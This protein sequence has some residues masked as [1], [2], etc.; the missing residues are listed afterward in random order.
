MQNNSVQTR[1]QILVAL[2]AMEWDLIK[3]WAM[4]GHSA[5]FRRLLEEGVHGEDSPGTGS[6]VRP[7][8]RNEM[9]NLM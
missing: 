5:T 7:H 4:T 1:R 6:T 3:K 2:D 8:L 9:W